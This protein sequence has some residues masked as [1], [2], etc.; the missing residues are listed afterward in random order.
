MQIG[1]VGLPLAGKTTFF[2]L[3][4][5][6]EERRRNRFIKQRKVYTGSAVVPDQ[7]IEFLTRMFKP[8]RKLTPKFS[9]K[10]SLVYVQKTLRHQAW[11][12]STWTKCAQPMS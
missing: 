10:I 2:N 5:A 1:L 12:V 6:E 11:P 8:K 7:R 9:L 4:T 3:L